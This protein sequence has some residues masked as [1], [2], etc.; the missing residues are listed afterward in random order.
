M[1]R[2]PLTLMEMSVVK[3]GLIVLGDDGEVSISLMETCSA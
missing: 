2:F 1:V 3:A